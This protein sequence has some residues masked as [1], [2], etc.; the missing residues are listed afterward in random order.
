MNSHQKQPATTRAVLFD[1]G[2]VL[3]RFKDVTPYREWEQRLQLAEGELAK[4]VFSN[5]ISRRAMVGQSTPEEV[6][7]EVQK[8]LALSM[9]DLETLQVDVWKGGAWDTELLEFIRSLRP[10][11]KTGI[12]SDAWSDARMMIKSFVNESLFDVI[13]FSAEEGLRKPEPEIYLR[14]LTKLEVSP[15]EAIFVDDMPYNVEAAR[16]LGMQTILFTDSATVIQ[17]IRQ[18]IGQE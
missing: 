4:I 12:I 9:A 6:W 2:G 7:A 15:E 11:Y 5:P 8:Q 14:A 10:T 17:T 3:F 18:L 16:R 13:V 1:V